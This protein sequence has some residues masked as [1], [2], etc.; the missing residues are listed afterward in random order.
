MKKEGL[1][2]DLAKY[3]DL[4]YSWK[5]YKKESAIIIKLIKKH[6]K[7]KGRE[8]L[9]AG[10]GTG[11]H[12]KYF[13]KNFKCVGFD[14]NQGIVNAARKSVKGVVFKKANMINFKFNKKFDVITSLFSSIGY[15]KTFPNLKKTIN[16]FSKHLKKRGVVIIEPWFNKAQFKPGFQ[17]L[18]TYQDDKFKIARLT[19]SKLKGKISILDMRFLIGEK[20]KELKY[21][22]DKHEL[23]L[24]DIDK[25]L[26]LMKNAGLKAKYL[27]N[28]LMKD[29]GLFI[30]VK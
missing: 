21:F 1:Y 29:R 2:K 3:Y 23:G 27:K 26:K 4:I 12:L 17:I 19:S 5:D 25:T 15:V 9:E 6:K 13:K 8:L 20:G 16:N 10:C 7:S 24:F 22:V 11:H 30:G 28:G 14:I 18:H